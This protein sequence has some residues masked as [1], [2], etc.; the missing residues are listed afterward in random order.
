MIAYT[1]LTQDRR[2]LPRLRV[3][4]NT[5]GV[6]EP[7]SKIDKRRQLPLGSAAMVWKSFA[8]WFKIWALSAL[9]P[10]RSKTEALEMWEI[11]ECGMPRTLRKHFLKA[12]F[13]DFLSF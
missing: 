2:G 3:P 5:L 6:V 1:T 10:A 4:Q 8:C 12:L 11:I 7:S 13:K 9:Q